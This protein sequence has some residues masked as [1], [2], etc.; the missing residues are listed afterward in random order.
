LAGFGFGVYYVFPLSLL[1]F[2][3]ALLLNLFFFLLL[4]MILGMIMLSLNVENLLQQFLVIVFFFWERT[5]ITSILLKNLVAHR[6][7]N[8]KTTVMY[9]LSLVSE[10]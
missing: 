6:V 7:R 10:R 3:L 2:N 8:R 5:A 9:A 4:G 1:S